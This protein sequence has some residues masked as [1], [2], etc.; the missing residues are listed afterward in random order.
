MD[1]TA[2]RERT[3]SPAYL[4]GL[5]H[6]RGGHVQPLSMT[7]GFARA[8][9]AAG[10]R[11]HDRSAVEA[12]ERAGGR[13]RVRTR[14]GSVDAERVVL[15]T[16]AYTHALPGTLGVARSFLPMVSIIAATA[17]LPQSVRAEVLPGGI[18]FAD[19]RR[20][21]LYGRLDRDH[22]LVFGCAG[23]AERAESLGG[24]RRLLH[25]M[26]R[27]FPGLGDVPIEYRWGGRIAV[28]PDLM[29]HLHEPEPGLTAALGYSGRG[30]VNTSLMARTLVRRLLGADERELPFPV[31]TIA[32]VPG[33]AL[34]SRALPL[35][36]PALALR[37][38]F[39]RR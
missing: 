36:A 24:L 5:L 12:I 31:S 38:R 33:H 3:G 26:R 9:E 14:G 6:P 29:P 1:G 32:T 7:R 13:W 22:R 2:I 37:D 34:L 23:S 19:T 10:A 18:T 17:P 27:T 16:N 20:A 11:L 15:A 4:S 21:I 39:D 30:I 25:G 28:T 35:L 8:A